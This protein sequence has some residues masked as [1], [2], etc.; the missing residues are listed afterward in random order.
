MN[1]LAIDDE[2]L[3]LDDLRLALAEAAPDCCCACFSSPAQ[4]L[5]HARTHP[6]DAA[7]LDIEMGDVNG[8][9]LAKQLKDLQPDLHIIF[10]TGNCLQEVRA[11]CNGIV[12]YYTVALGV[13]TADPLIAYGHP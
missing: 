12:L 4:A 13:Q 11:E 10:V 9:A 8:L 6:L 2:P 5:T 1:F 3:C 7:F